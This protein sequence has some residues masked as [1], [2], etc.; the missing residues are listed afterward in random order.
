MRHE[1][2]LR[3][4][5]G[6]RRI[7]GNPAPGILGAAGASRGARASCP[8]GGGHVGG[9]L[10]VADIQVTLY[11]SVMNVRPDDPTWA[12]RDR[13]VLSEGHASAELYATLA[14]R[15]YIPI[16]E[17]ATFDSIGSRLRGHPDMTKLRAIDMSTG[18]LGR[19]FSSAVGLALGAR[20]GFARWRTQHTLSSATV[21]ASR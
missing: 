4:H 15:G 2:A 10:A 6:A 7:R 12:D 3:S 20:L 16:A 1:M 8:C 14:L 5:L 9:P 11:F 18:S 19:G 13:L 21:N 17:L